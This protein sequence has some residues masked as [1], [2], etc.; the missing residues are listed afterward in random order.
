LLSERFDIPQAAG[1]MIKRLQQGVPDEAL[2]NQEGTIELTMDGVLVCRLP[3][4]ELPA[5]RAA[6]AEI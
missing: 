2:R 5:L 4:A 3:E 1:M 6:L